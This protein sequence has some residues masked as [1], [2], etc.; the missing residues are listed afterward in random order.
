MRR[1]R[2]DLER[3]LRMALAPGPGAVPGA[4]KVSPGSKLGEL[5]LSRDSSWQPVEQ[6]HAMLHLGAQRAPAAE[7]VVGRSAALSACE[8]R[9]EWRR[10][11]LL[12]QQM[13]TGKGSKTL[14]A[15]NAM[16][17]AYEKVDRWSEALQALSNFPR[18]SLQPDEV[19]LNS[20]CSSAEKCSSW[21][22]ALQ[23]LRL[24]DLIGFNLLLQSCMHSSA[25][26]GALHFLHHM[27]SSE[28]ALSAM[29]IVPAIEACV[30]WRN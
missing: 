16:L 24:A 25:W 8:R 20:C 18:L 9:H 13:W 23:L 11:M 26:R 21:R 22:F 15:G 2:G 27:R 7:D 28:T 1:R 10:A 12:L 30:P 5:R 4:A 14:V 29:S 3:G 6:S 19:S 17:A